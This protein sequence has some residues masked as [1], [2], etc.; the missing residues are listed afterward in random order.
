MDG[1]DTM[2]EAQS[3]PDGAGMDGLTSDPEVDDSEVVLEQ[4]ALFSVGK[5]ADILEHGSEAKKNVVMMEIQQFLDHCLED[6]LQV[7]VPVLCLHVHEWSHELQIAAA[8]ALLEVVNKTIPPATAKMISAASF[9][10]VKLAMVDTIYESWGEILVSVLPNV[11]W[12]DDE[13]VRVLSLIDAHANRSSEVSR[14]LAA[15]VIG[16]MSLCVTP[17]QVGQFI[18]PRALRLCQDKDIEVRGMSTESLAFIGSALDQPTVETVVWEQIETLL[19]DANARIRAASLRS[20]ARILENHRIKQ[21]PVHVFGATLPK[22]FNEFCEFANHAAAEDQRL[23]DDDS[24][25]LLEIFSEVFGELLYGTS[26]V[27]R[28]QSPGYPW[29]L[30]HS[31]FLRMATCNGPVVRRHCAYNLPGVTAVLKGKHAA[32]LLT[33]C[34]FLSRDPDPETRW[35]LAA[36]LHQT[37]LIMRDYLDSE[38]LIKGTI[39]ILHDENPLVRMN[40]LQHFADIL[41]TVGNASTDLGKPNGVSDQQQLL[42]EGEISEIQRLGQT[43]PRKV[44]AWMEPIFRNMHL[45]S[46]GNWRTQE[47]LAQQIRMSARSI[48]SKT[49]RVSVL[50]ALYSMA[51]ESTYRVRKSVMEAAVHVMHQLSRSDQEKM[52]SLFRIE[53]AQGGVFWMRIAFLD[54][55]VYA[56]TLFSKERF[57]AIFSKHCLKLYGDP[58]PNVRLKLAKSLVHLWYFCGDLPEF[59]MALR[60]FEVDED[61]DV[62]E[63]TREAR[64]LAK[65]QS[66]D[67]AARHERDIED[68]RRMDEER[69]IDEL[70]SR[71][72]DL[73]EQEKQATGRYAGAALTTARVAQSI[74]AGGHTGSHTGGSQGVGKPPIPSKS[75][76]A[77]S[78]TESHSGKGLSRL[79]SPRKTSQK[80]IMRADVAGSHLDMQPEEEES[81]SGILANQASL[82]TPVTSKRNS[83][84]SNIG[85]AKAVDELAGKGAKKKQTW[86]RKLTEKFRKKDKSKS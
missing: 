54:S 26:Q 55:A 85:E 44:R 29:E 21:P 5:M 67:S 80:D 46:D 86:T 45:L 9:R 62:V 64:Q 84:S 68:A 4:E 58:V 35:N 69:C 19:N 3:K 18:L 47:M 27:M 34:E 42:C 23:V 71:E 81:L 65:L 57:N 52:S 30:E 13:L 59:E 49:L 60:M 16:S 31:A 11:S 51:E 33:I 40:A 75:A 63:F 28:V 10:V 38:M 50:P 70:R 15:R 2:E 6:T 37:V 12:S 77:T 79:I 78:I 48:P 39:S 43:D 14:K 72:V 41:N 32:E 66:E 83:S 82:S 24:Y 53:W 36:G 76:S 1:D 17:E 74:A 7:L 73:D 61:P 8:E 56:T 20:M 25:L 22:V